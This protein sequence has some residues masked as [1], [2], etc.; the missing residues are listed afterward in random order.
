MEITTTDT[1]KRISLTASSGVL[2]EKQLGVLTLTCTIP[3]DTFRVTAKPFSKD[4]TAKEILIDYFTKDEL[5]QLLEA[6]Q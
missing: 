1:M 6:L 3:Q 5:K 4:G 2:P